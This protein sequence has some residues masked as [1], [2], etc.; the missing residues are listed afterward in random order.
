MKKAFSVASWNVEHFKGEPARVK[1]IIQFLE[2]EKPDVFALIEVEGKEVFQTLTS[3]M[4]DYSFH[5]TEGRQCQEILVGAKR[6][7]TSF[8]TQ[9]T[10]FKAGNAYLRPGALLTII[11]GNKTYT[12]LF[13]HTKSHST[14]L[15]L[16]LRDD[17]FDKAAKFRKILDKAAGGPGQANYIF[18]GDLNPL[19]MDYPYNKDIDPQLE[20]KK[21]DRRA[22]YRKMQRLTKD[23]K[24]TFW[25]GTGSSYPK[26]DLDHVVAAG[27]LKFKKFGEAAV[28]V[29]GW[30]KEPTEAKQNQWISKY[31][32]HAMIYF[33]IM[34]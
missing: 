15:G 25:N 31:S 21:L 23:E 18:L 6:T 8:F 3:R 10:E 19:G 24:F 12:L 27:H 22:K 26:A 16:G 13:L 17:M 34:H 4:P 14:P 1:R 33:E 9:K 5:I 32:D 2:A 7:F 30:P 20:L 28:T 11:A 29:L